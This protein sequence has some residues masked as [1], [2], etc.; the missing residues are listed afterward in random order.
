MFEDE[1]KDN[2]IMIRNLVLL[3][4][5]LVVG[6]TLMFIFNNKNNKEDTIDKSMYLTVITV[7]FETVNG[8][9]KSTN[10]GEEKFYIDDVGKELNSNGL[11]FTIESL[12]T[13]SVKFELNN[14]YISEEE[15]LCPNKQC[16]KGTIISLD[17]TKTINITDKS[18]TYSYNIYFQKKQ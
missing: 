11:S 17:S 13:K 10:I 9:F 16:V 4:A 18:N 15:K 2:Y 7:K 5:V 14:D 6:F 3:I 8:V 1:K 12:D